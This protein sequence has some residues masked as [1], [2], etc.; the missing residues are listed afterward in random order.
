MGEAALAWLTGGLLLVTGVL[1][2]ATIDY[3]RQSR[4]MVQEMKAARAGSVQPRLIPTLHLWPGGNGALRIVNVGPGAALN[5]DV[6]FSLEPDGPVRRVR[7]PLMSAGEGINFHPSPDEEPH[8]LFR[9]DDLTSRYRIFRL[10]ATY[11]DA[12]GESHAAEEELD[13]VEFWTQ[14]K[15]AQGIPPDDWAEK[16]AKAVE[17]MEKHLATIAGKT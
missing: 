15:T 16:T 13:L 17:K 14:L 10:R 6:E 1:A 12:F 4:L 3:A 5:V 7:W 2:Y 9:L 8:A 11:S